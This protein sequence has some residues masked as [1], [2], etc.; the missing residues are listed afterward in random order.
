MDS[1]KTT[2]PAPLPRTRTI[3]EVLAA[4]T[5]E[6]MK[7]EGVQGTGQTEKNGKP[8]LMILVDTLTPALSAKLPKV[9]EGYPVV[10]HQSGTVKAYPKR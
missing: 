1:G 3:T 5:D 2:P 7:I 8:A 4:Y 9:V 10:I 6:W